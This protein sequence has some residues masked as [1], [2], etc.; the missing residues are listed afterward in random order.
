MR[1]GSLAERHAQP[2]IIGTDRPRGS[3]LSVNREKVS[4][5]NRRLAVAVAVG[6]ALIGLALRYFARERATIDALQ[7]LI[8]WY[9]FARDHGVGALSEAFTNYT[10]LYSYLLLI[11]APFDGLGQPLSL[12]K[13]ISAVFEFACAI[14]VAQIVW[15]ATKAPMRASLAFCGVWLAPTVICNGAVWGQADSIWAFFTLVSVSLFMQG[16]NGVLPFA[17]AV[18]VKAQ[19]VFLGPLVLGMILRRKIHWASLAA[20][21]GVYVVLAIPVLVAGRSIASVFTVYMDQA[22]TF[23]HL[24]MNAANIWVFAGG[25]P[26][27]IGVAAGVALAAAGG[28]ALSYFAVRSK[29]EEPEFIL[30]LACA[31]LLLM[32]YLLPKMHDR[33]FYAFEL[34]AIAL[35]CLNPRYLPFAV[36]AQVDGVLSYLGFEYGI[37]MGLPPA[38]LCNTFLGF[39]LVVDLWRGERGSRFPKGAWLG[40]AASNAGLFSYLF[41]ADPGWNMSPAYLTAAILVTVMALMLIRESRCA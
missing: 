31:S 10:P 37:V 7:Y 12:V 16:R 38:V 25:V 4:D 29:R 30:L 32:P 34:A 17:A 36:I 9:V 11:A 18:S 21:P 3:G 28:V 23:H 39:Y 5:G 35:A 20:V 33:Y 1:Q 24:T 14:A 40:F 13:A 6:C 19:G 27:T 15:Q 2:H 41:L 22:D 8:P 26:Y